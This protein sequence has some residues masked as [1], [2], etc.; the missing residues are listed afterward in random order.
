MRLHVAVLADLILP[1]KQTSMWGVVVG[2]VV[3]GIA[4]V[5]IVMRLIRKRRSR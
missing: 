2:L 5:L 3:V 1:P 4:A